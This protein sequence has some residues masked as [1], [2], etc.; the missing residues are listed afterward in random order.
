MLHFELKKQYRV[1][2]K[3]LVLFSIS[4]NKKQVLCERERERENRERERRKGFFFFQNCDDTFVR[5]LTLIK[6][7]ISLEKRKYEEVLCCVS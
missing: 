7:Q 4:S 5:V 1:R 6:T 2:I 3:N